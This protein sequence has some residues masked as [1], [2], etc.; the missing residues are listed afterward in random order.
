[1]VGRN[2]RAKL[3]GSG[4]H[5]LIR[6]AQK[7]DRHAVFRGEQDARFSV[8]LDFLGKGADW[9]LSLPRRNTR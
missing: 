5:A 9:C 2:L 6:L 1:V 8:P 7:L 3:L 4:H